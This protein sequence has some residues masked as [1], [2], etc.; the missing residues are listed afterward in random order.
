MD[1]WK[2]STCNADNPAEAQACLSCQRS[3]QNDQ[4]ASGP[5]HR[6]TQLEAPVPAKTRAESALDAIRGAELLQGSLSQS[7][8]GRSP[9]ATSAHDEPASSGDAP[10]DAPQTSAPKGSDSAK[11]ATVSISS[12]D[13]NEYTAQMHDQQGAGDDDSETRRGPKLSR[14]LP[15]TILASIGAAALTWATLSAI[16]SEQTDPPS[17][18]QTPSDVD[19]KA[20]AQ[21][22][23]RRVIIGLTD[24]NRES[25][26]SACFRLS[27]NAN[28]DCRVSRLTELGEL[29]L[30]E[31]D[32]PAMEAHR[33]EV[34]NSS[35]AECVSAGACSAQDW[36]SCK[37]YSVLRYELG[38]KPQDHFKE[39]N[40]PAVCVT[41]ADARA[42]CEWEGMSLPTSTQWEAIAR[43]GDD[44]LQPWGAFWL[45][46][47][48]NWGERDMTGFPIPGRLDGHEHT[49]PVTAFSDGATPEGI[50][51]LFGNVAEWVTIDREGADENMGGVRGG[52]YADDVRA[53][54]ATK[55]DELRADERRTT[56]G[57]RCVREL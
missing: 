11:H 15:L 7:G 57:F 1:T 51:N 10:A 31:L 52:S 48:L 22:P 53:F 9:L 6:H 56:V 34:A 14:I 43:G 16:K 35:Y 25:V 17:P 27:D 41:L 46:G 45:P 29:P 50:Q 44:R 39:P 38:A 5:A 36:D 12:A 32:M 21:I 40:R 20:R 33:Y 47:V 2:C 13:F 55:E 49:G 42:Y 30:R 19:L 28:Y 54:R 26:L 37:V 3:R 23:A 18:A 8:D 4:S 24:D